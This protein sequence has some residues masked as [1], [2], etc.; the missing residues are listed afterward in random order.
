MKEKYK[1]WR[2]QYALSI[3]TI[4]LFTAGIILVSSSAHLVGFFTIKGIADE[5]VVSFGN[6]ALPVLFGLLGVICLGW[7]IVRKQL[8]KPLLYLGSTYLGIQLVVSLMMG[9][10]SVIMDQAFDLNGEAIKTTIDMIIR[11]IQIPLRAGG[12]LFLAEIV[13]ASPIRSAG[14]FGKLLAAVTVYTLFQYLVGYM[15]TSPILLVF[16]VLIAA[17]AALIFWAFVYLESKKAGE[18]LEK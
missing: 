14:L 3:Q 11:V 7:C 15:G 17:A 9:G 8:L 6:G 4:L 12:C 13:I 18:K 16:R 5:G 10:V 1:R 2:E